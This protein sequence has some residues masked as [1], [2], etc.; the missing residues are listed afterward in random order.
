MIFDCN[1]GLTYIIH[2]ILFQLLVLC[3]AVKWVNI[4]NDEVSEC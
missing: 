4:S 1:I 2:D 3:L